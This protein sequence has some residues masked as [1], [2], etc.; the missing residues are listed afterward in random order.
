M[1]RKVKYGKVLVVLFLTCLVWV[2]ADLAMDEDLGDRPATV[3]VDESS[4]P[5][6]WVSLAG[7]SS[8]DIKVTVSG[9][10]TAVTDVRKMLREGGRLEFNFDVVAETM[11]EPGTYPLVLLP[12]LQ[13]DKQIK[14]RSLKV[15]SCNP[16]TIEVKVVRLEKKALMVRC[17]DEQGLLIENAVSEPTQVD[18]WVPDDWSREN[19]TA[20]V[21][22]TNSEIK[23]ARTS[24]VPKIP[25]IELS[26][27]QMRKSSTTV[28]VT[29][30]P[31]VDMLSDHTVT[32]AGLGVCFGLNL[33]GK[34]K[35][36]VT[37]LNMVISPV[38][39]RATAEAKRAYERQPFQMTLYILD[40][41][42]NVTGWQNRDVV[43]N[44][45]E[46]FVRRDEIKLHQQTVKAKARFRLKR[47]SDSQ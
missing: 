16:N 27:G 17:E 39:I 44:F 5:K 8:V 11:D 1:L 21:Q 12:F 15:K 36:E 24:P 9:P 22:L 41:D 31:E 14:Q 19:L 40:G 7:G 13:K 33:Q 18:M 23:Q 42:E 20:R 25:F 6:L 28:N 37:N 47:I 26:A 29:T 45:P 30:P 4:A 38:R 32:N 46:E 34:Y 10:H 35:V 2:W 3:V 43:Y